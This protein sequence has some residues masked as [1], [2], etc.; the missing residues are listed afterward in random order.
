M[1]FV[2][3]LY[4]GNQISLFHH[5]SLNNYI[6]IGNYILF[7]IISLRHYNNAYDNARSSR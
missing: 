6:L 1:R 3:L 5:I 2:L 4:K 7:D